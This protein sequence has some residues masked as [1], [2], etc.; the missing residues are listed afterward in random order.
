M[1]AQRSKKESIMTLEDWK[2]SLHM[3]GRSALT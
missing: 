2:N 3:S 1:E